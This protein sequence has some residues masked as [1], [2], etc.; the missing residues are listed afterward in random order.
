MSPSPPMI[1]VSQAFEVSVRSAPYIF[2][3]ALCWSLHLTS[4]TSSVDSK[5]HL[6]PVTITK[7]STK[8]T[9]SPRMNHS[10][11]RVNVTSV[12]FQPMMCKRCDKSQNLFSPSFFTAELQRVGQSDPCN[13]AF[14]PLLC[15]S[16]WCIEHWNFT[17]LVVIACSL[18]FKSCSAFLTIWYRLITWGFVSLNFPLPC[19]HIRVTTVKGTGKQILFQ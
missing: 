10:H 14:P 15:H 18:F 7:W 3:F 19:C 9:S 17:A 11:W 5:C 13:K 6:R 16:A 8:I 1:W 12:T 4:W 2:I